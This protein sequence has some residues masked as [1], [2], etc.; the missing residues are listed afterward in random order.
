MLALPLV[1]LILFC[2]VPMG[3]LI[4]AFE[5]YSVSLLRIFCKEGLSVIE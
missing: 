5:D 2:Y 1:Y 4:I 3:S